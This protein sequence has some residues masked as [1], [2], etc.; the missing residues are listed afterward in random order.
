MFE[1]PERIP[2]PLA[3]RALVDRRLIFADVDAE[4]RERALRFLAERLEREGAVPS[5][6]DLH[7]K[8]LERE[9]QGSTAIGNGIAIPHCKLPRLDRVVVA[10]GVAPGGV[11]METPD[12]EPVRVFFLVVSPEGAPAV[13][14]QSLAAISKWLKAGHNLERVRAATTSAEVTASLTSDGIGAERG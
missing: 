7:A 6:D 4:S 5:A 8:L 2:R 12:H 1:S 9:Q 10:I 14:L 11:S 3:T 13:H